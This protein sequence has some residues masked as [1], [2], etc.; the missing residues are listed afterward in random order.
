[1]NFGKS[2]GVV[3]SWV[4]Y[5]QPKLVSTLSACASCENIFKM[6]EEVSKDE[7]G[8]GNDNITI[9]IEK[10]IH[11]RLDAYYKR[12]M[13]KQPVCITTLQAPKVVIHGFFLYIQ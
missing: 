8:R 6:D 10:G 13:K 9:K 11:R 1:M 2:A 3:P 7:S 5:C 12:N 4:L